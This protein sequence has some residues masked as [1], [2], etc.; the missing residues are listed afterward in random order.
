MELKEIPTEL[1][2]ISNLV[3]NRAIKV[4]KSLGPGLLESV[5][6]ECL[7]YELVS[8]GLNVQKE[9]AVPVIWN[10][11]K[12]EHGFRVDL[13]VDNRIVLEIKSIESLGEVHTAQMLTYLRLTGCRLGLL[14]NF[15]VYRLADGI[16][17][18]II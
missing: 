12:L 7:F 2:A 11:L 17:R 16:K 1:N 18:L 6:K 3:L 9:K 10:N 14:L 13:M 4:H 8:A 5:Y 15:N